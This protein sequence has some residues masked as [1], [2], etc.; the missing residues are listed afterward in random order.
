MEATNEEKNLCID[1]FK[2][3]DI[4]AKLDD[5]GSVYIETEFEGVYDTLILHDAEVKYRAE[6]QEENECYPEEQEQP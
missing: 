6:I 5:T 1:W 4:V 2:D 3:R